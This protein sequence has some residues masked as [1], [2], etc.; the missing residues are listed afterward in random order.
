MKTGPRYRFRLYVAGDTQ[1]SLQAVGNL[2]E[3]CRS[4]L[5]ERHEIEIVDVFKDPVR[6]LDDGILMTPTLLMLSPV[7]VTRIVGTLSKRGP[8]LA[9]LRIGGATA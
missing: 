5:P 2:T 4:H 7:P 8:V 3:L 9:A 1:N 6:A